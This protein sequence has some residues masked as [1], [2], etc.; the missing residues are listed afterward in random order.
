MQV[1]VFAFI[2][3]ALPQRRRKSGEE[4]VV[5]TVMNSDG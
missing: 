1:D 3:P 5:D 2:G 4:G